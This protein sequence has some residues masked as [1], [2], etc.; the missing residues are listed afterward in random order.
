MRCDRTGIVNAACILLVLAVGCQVR[1]RTDS[2][3]EASRTS[4]RFRLA[5]MAD[6]HFHDVYADSIDGLPAADVSGG[7]VTIRTMESQLNS[8]RLFNEN[9]FALRA[10]LD[11]A[12]GRG[13][14]IVA[15]AGDFSD[16]GQ[17]AHLR[18]LAEVLDRY[19][20]AYGVR[21]FAITGNHDPTRPFAREA[22]KPDYLGSDGRPQPIFST[23]HPVCRRGLEAIS[24]PDRA[25]PLSP[26]CTDEVKE[27]GYAG[28]LEIMSDHG[29]YPDSEDHY[30]ETPFSSYDVSSYSYEIAMREAALSARVHEVCYEGTG[31]SW[32]RPHYTNCFELPDVSYLVEP[33]PGLWLLMLDAN[34]YRPAANADPS[35]PTSPTNFGGAGD[36]G[37]NSVVT[38][39]EYLVDWIGDVARRADSQ[40][41]ALV[42]V[43]HYPMARFHGPSVGVA[44]R[45][46]GSGPYQPGR[47]PSE[48]TGGRLADTGLKLHIGGHMHMN[49]TGFIRGG[50]AGRFL[51]NIQVPSLAAYVPAYKVFLFE[52]R[53]SL[54]VQTI[55]VRDVPGFNDLFEY[56]RTEWEY[57]DSIGYDGI[58]DR[59]VLES[60]T[61][62]EFVDWHLRELTRLR[63]LPNDWPA[64][65]RAMLRA[66]S[67]REIL[68][69]SLLD[70][71]L[72]LDECARLI[73]D[74]REEISERSGAFDLAWTAAQDEASRLAGESGFAL[75]DFDDWT[76]EDLAVDFYRLRNAGRLAAADIPRRR[77]DQYR[78]IGEALT[79]S[80][81]TSAGS[82]EKTVGHCFKTRFGMLFDVMSQSTGGMPDV[83][84]QLDLTSGT[85]RELRGQVRPSMD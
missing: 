40:G 13:I 9:Y 64:E 17:P 16:D 50:E 75:L 59:R 81:A 45:L 32:K 82:H 85:V 2:G 27:L 58:W 61:Y 68:I 71:A 80:D 79:T 12:V 53:N 57:L 4:S 70:S 42:A 7:T 33:V 34:V 19:R 14:R 23:G 10:A 3:D 54:E 8:T 51:F 44:E 77:M 46:R 60:E 29:F 48:E 31:G 35:A 1:Q 28:L 41:K 30:F 55:V 25:K 24:A 11:D 47:M 65:V 22:G 21:F 69:A 49:N 36:A 37:F 84:F 43:S 67:G 5:V 74:E 76:G 73:P 63:F 72:S 15:L 20:D 26:V 6:V 56:Y 83:Y 66:M 62:Y 38:H 39:K 78:V 52:N 18:G